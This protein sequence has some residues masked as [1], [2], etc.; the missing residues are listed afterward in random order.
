MCASGKRRRLFLLP[1][2][3]RKDDPAI[4]ALI[5]E[6]RGGIMSLKRVKAYFAEK[7]IA[8]RILVFDQSTATVAEAAEVLHCEP[9]RIAKSLAFQGDGR[10]VL[11]VA[12]GDARIDNARFKK[13]F[14]YKAKMLKVSETER[15]VGHAAGGVCPFAVNPGTDVYLDVSLKRYPTVFPACGSADSAIEMTPQE[16]ELYAPVKGWVDVVRHEEEEK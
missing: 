14:G 1:G 8:E 16:L 9:G 7:G 10:T 2:W 3:K 12:A 6:M 13:T 11:V 15:L 4:I 5:I